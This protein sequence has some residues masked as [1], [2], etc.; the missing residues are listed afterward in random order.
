MWSAPEIRLLIDERRNR[1]MEYCGCSKVSFWAS[2]AGNIFICK[3][4]K[5]LDKYIM[6]I[7]FVRSRYLTL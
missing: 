5:L 3:K 7:K 1:N 6:I 4:L 2:V